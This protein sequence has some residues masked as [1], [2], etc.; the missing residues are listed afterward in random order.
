MKKER[1]REKM[2]E[3]GN[4]DKERENEREKIKVERYKDW[5]SESHH[6]ISS[7]MKQEQHTGAV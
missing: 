4:E 5:K 3:G 2:N 6:R 1:E 7:Q